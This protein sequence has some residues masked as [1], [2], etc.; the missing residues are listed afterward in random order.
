MVKGS[1][2]KM[3]DSNLTPTNSTP[4]L[5]DPRI[6]RTRNSAMQA[7]LELVA[8]GGIQACSFENV[9][10]LSGISRSTLYRHWE[11]KTQLLKDAL[12]AQIIERIAPD[13]GNFRDDM[14]SAML[15]LGYALGATPWGA[16][17]AQ[18]MAAAAVDT[19]VAEIQQAAA[20]YHSSV[21]T[22]IITRAVERGELEADID[23]EH[24][25]L[26]FSAPVFY[27]HLFYRQSAT[28]KWITRHV[29][30]TVLLLTGK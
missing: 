5:N 17:V 27:R 8:K 21:E 16:M 19:D 6:M 10:E 15:D 2:S 29:D 18:L 9:S 14:L 23:A 13:T 30:V 12:R 25:V 1:A 11:D 22:G 24:V 20:E 26:L 3:S 7:V 4:N 28:A